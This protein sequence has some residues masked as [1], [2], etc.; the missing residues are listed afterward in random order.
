MDDTRLLDEFNKNGSRHAFDEIVTRYQAFVLATCRRELSNQT[1]AED[2][3]QVVFL[4]L[5]R[6]ASLMN[7]RQSLPGWLFKTSRFVCNDMRKEELRR[8]QRE[9]V[10]YQERS[11]DQGSEL[12]A[13]L[14]PAMNDGLASLPNSDREILLMRYFTG[15]SL[16]E[17]GTALGVSESAAKTRA[18]RALSKLRNY[19]NRRGYG[20]E[21][22]AFIAAIETHAAPL[23][24]TVTTFHYGSVPKAAHMASHLLRKI[25]FM[26]IKF[27]AAIL[28][29][30]ISSAATAYELVNA[31]KV[32]NG[33]VNNRYDVVRS[34]LNPAM[35][36]DLTKDKLSHITAIINAQYGKVISV[37]H[38][39]AVRKM[40]GFDVIYVPCKF[41]HGASDIAVVFDKS[42]KVAGLWFVKYGAPVDGGNPVLDRLVAED[43]ALAFV[44]NN[45]PAIVGHLDG[46]MST[47]FPSAKLTQ[48]SLA[49]NAQFGR[50]VSVGSPITKNIVGLIVEYVPCQFQHGS[51]QIKVVFDPDG[52]VGGLWLVNHGSV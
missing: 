1:M 5:F 35:K 20:V 8:V 4:L 37:G 39:I 6:K 19:F 15:L 46:T 41:E 31:S 2:A 23:H 3:A 49:L 7:G 43:V 17:A 44:N 42:Q 12:W 34:D 27:A 30:S 29:L 38:V 50:T 11:S 33:V 51:L 45:Y 24:E 22:N 25:A 26:K 14:E 9:Q 21:S 52:K 18:S 40:A 32:A 13:Q 48:V 36:S 28:L 47:A 10:A 16:A